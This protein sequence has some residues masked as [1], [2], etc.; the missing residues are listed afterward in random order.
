MLKDTWK[1]AILLVLLVQTGISYA[2]NTY[3]G[4]RGGILLTSPGTHA[5]I[6]ALGLLGGYQ[7][8]GY[9]WSAEAEIYG[10]IGDSTWQGQGVALS[11]V[12]RM[13]RIGDSNFIF[14]PKFKIGVL[15]S[16][17]TLSGSTNS[18]TGLNWGI[19][20]LI[21]DSSDIFEFEVSGSFSKL[22]GSD[23]VMFFS[24]NYIKPL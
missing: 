24:L 16:L 3:S 7:F 17:Y 10:S 13:G 2:N 22:G 12:Y 5:D 23:E 18:Y 8:T 11:A 15:R 20:M 14:S 6:A 21:G 4:L 1:L 19:G 9:S